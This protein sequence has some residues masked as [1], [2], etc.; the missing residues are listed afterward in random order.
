MAFVIGSMDQEPHILNLNVKNT[1]WHE[2]L[3]KILCVECI[4]YWG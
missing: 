4:Q 1:K 3:L 2:S